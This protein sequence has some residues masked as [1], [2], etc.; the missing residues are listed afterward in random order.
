MTASLNQ[1]VFMS[2]QVPD[3]KGD[4]K[5]VQ[6]GDAEEKVMKKRKRVTMAE[7]PDRERGDKGAKQVCTVPTLLGVF[8]SYSH[9][10][11]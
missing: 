11:I 7:E 3:V 4:V 9:S 8:L 1:I 5:P 10:L 2:M 6:K